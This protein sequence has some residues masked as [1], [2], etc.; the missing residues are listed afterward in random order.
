[1]GFVCLFSIL[2]LCRLEGVLVE[3]V[4]TE[5]YCLNTDDMAACFP[6]GSP[7]I[8][9]LFCTLI[10][11]LSTLSHKTGVSGPFLLF[12]ILVEMI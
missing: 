9:L 12:L 3:F 10:L 6:N 4:V 11:T 2:P 5:A 7:F 8:S 1:M